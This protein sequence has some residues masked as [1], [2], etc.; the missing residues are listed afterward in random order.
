MGTHRLGE[1]RT[2]GRGLLKEMAEIME[3]QP[4]LLNPGEALN[5]ALVIM[6][7]AIKNSLLKNENSLFEIILLYPRAL[8]FWE[9]AFHRFFQV[10]P[11]W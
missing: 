2:A 11:L 3:S 8:L 9:C 5:E 1:V 10:S 7:F 6:I 4:P